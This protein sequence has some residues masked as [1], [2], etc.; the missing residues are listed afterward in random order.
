ME[1]SVR[2][3]RGMECEKSMAPVR[4]TRIWLHKTKTDKQVPYSSRIPSRARVEWK[5]TRDTVGHLLVCFD[6]TKHPEFGER[7]Q[8]MKR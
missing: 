6:F 7:S 1:I 4:H 8:S 2:P 5:S 3:G